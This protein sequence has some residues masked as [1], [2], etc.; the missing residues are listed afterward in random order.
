MAFSDPQ[1]NVGQFGL[2]EGMK[3]ADFG[4]G[5]G[6]YTLAAAHKVGD[7][8]RVYAIEI[9]QELLKRVKN[10]SHTEHMGNID[11]LWG[12]L[13]V[14]GGSKL[15][16]ARMDAVIMANMLFQAEHR[17]A[18]LNEAHRVLKPNGRIFFVDWSE[19]FGNL[20]PRPED[21]ISREAARSLA[22]ECGFI[23]EKELSTVGDHHYGFIFKKA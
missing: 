7:T 13:E 11:V 22:K 10:L 21:V 16:D 20:G 14:S 19:S 4:S 17:G 8:G 18:V 5:S 23:V 15:P 6:H 1:K 3:V 2:R 12:D 9:Q